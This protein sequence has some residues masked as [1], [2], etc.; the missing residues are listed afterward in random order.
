MSVVFTCPPPAPR[1]GKAADPFGHRSRPCARVISRPCREICTVCPIA[2]WVGLVLCRAG[3]G[4]RIITPALDSGSDAQRPAIGIALIA[5]GS[6]L[7]GNQWWAAADRIGWRQHFDSDTLAGVAWEHQVISVCPLP[8]ASRPLLYSALR[9]N[10]DTAS[11]V[12][13][14]GSRAMTARFIVQYSIVAEDCRQ[15]FQPDCPCN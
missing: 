7:P 13:A 9:R 3:N 5:N 8:F 2:A 1:S 14:R 4:V 11:T 6:T 12:S 15:Y 10:C